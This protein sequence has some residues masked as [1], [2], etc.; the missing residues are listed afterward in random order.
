MNSTW[1]LFLQTVRAKKKKKTFTVSDTIYAFVQ[2]TAL[3]F[4]GEQILCSLMLFLWCVCV[5]QNTLFF[6]LFFLK[7]LLVTK[8]EMQHLLVQPDLKRGKKEKRK[9]GWNER[10]TMTL[11]NLLIIESPALFYVR[12]VVRLNTFF[13]DNCAWCWPRQ[14]TSISVV[15]HQSPT[16]EQLSSPFISN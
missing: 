4:Y 2:R 3:C 14:L 10:S 6:Y 5:S 12:V 15:R 7:V 13:R 11:S 8:G 1:S 16:K 9:S